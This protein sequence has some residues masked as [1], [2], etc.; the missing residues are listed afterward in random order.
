M[1]TLNVVLALGVLCCGT[2]DAQERIQPYGENPSYWQ[3]KGEPVLLLG[4]SKD[5]NLFQI[6]DLKAHLDELQAAGINFVRNTMSDRK[7]DRGD[8]P[9][10]V[11]AF[12]KSEAGK[13]DLHTWNPVYWERFERFLKWSR[14]RDVIVQIEVW[15]RFD[16]SQKNWLASP[17][18]PANNVNYTAENSGLANQYGDH[19]WRD[20]QPFFHTVPGMKRYQPIYDRVRKYQ[21]AFVAKMLSHSLAYPNVLYCMNNETSTPQPWGG[22]WM[23]FIQNKAKEK[24]VSVYVTDMFDDGWQAWVSKKVRHAIDHPKSYTFLD[25]SQINSRIFNEK[26]WKGLRWV[27]EQLKENPRPLNHVKIY[28]DGE[29]NWGSG[30]PVDGV[31]RFWR[32]LIG[33]SAACRFHRPGAGIGANAIAKACI[34]A[35]RKLETKVRFWEV[36][37]HQELLGQ[38]E[39]DEAYL[40]AQPGEKYI[41]F[42]TDG[43][44]VELDLSGHEYKF[45]LNWINIATGEWGAE[46]VVEGG[47]KVVIEAPEKGPWAAAIRK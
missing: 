41:L 31:E 6:P 22:Y 13:F 23:Q 1:R 4:G 44:A 35:A 45:V 2:L 19:P 47:G 11:A 10:E 5:D 37:V 9:H 18:R 28:S 15:D 26:H 12:G 24:G 42:F 20:K 43:G 32:N 8:S 7:G 33:G 16:H 21:E 38:R 34:G 17:W 29:T 36:E 39:E 40:A 3:Y 27:V 14:E 30:T 46:K 25:V